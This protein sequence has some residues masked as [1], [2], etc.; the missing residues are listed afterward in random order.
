MALAPRSSLRSLVLLMSHGRPRLS[1]FFSFT[2]A[3]GADAPPAV[4]PPGPSC[5]KLPVEEEFVLNPTPGYGSCSTPDKP[6]SGA[7]ED[8]KQRDVDPPPPAREGVGHRVVDPPRGGRGRRAPDEP[9]QCAQEHPKYPVPDNSSDKVCSSATPPPAPGP[10]TTAAPDVQPPVTPAPP[11]RS[12]HKLPDHE[13]SV[14]NPLPDPPSGHRL[15]P[16]IE[17]PARCTLDNPK[18]PT[19]DRGSCSPSEGASGD[20]LEDPLHRVPDPPRKP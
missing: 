17:E 2:T 16:V 10:C 18:Y 14:F 6:P 8:V 3:P 1:S 19:P 20:L 15:S 9:E 4:Q 5:H 7:S 11:N 12:G 13:E